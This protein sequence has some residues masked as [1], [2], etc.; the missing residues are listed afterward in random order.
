MF[1][2]T[3]WRDLRN[4]Y[5]RDK[6]TEST[7]TS[8]ALY[9]Q[10]KGSIPPHKPTRSSLPQPRIACCPSARSPV[11]SSMP[12][13]SR[14]VIQG[15]SGVP[16][17]MPRVACGQPTPVTT[18]AEV[19]DKKAAA[20]W[21]RPGI[22]NGNNLA[23]QFASQHADRTN[24]TAAEQHQRARLGSG[25]KNVEGVQRTNP[26]AVPCGPA[27]DAIQSGSSLILVI[28]VPG[29][30]TGIVQGHW[31]ENH[32]IRLATGE[33]HSRDTGDGNQ[34]AVIGAVG[35]TLPEIRVRDQAVQEAPATWLPGRPPT[36][37]QMLAEKV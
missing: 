31:T 17:T 10:M 16:E 12:A 34:A 19:Y 9:G 14:P 6:I 2:G 23:D 8:K 24:R 13:N 33:G 21:L 32:E 28:Q 22:T 11:A 35:R 20:G 27:I 29:I 7:S 3:I 30:P 4:Q 36:S 1:P 37:V 26:S 5:L 25:T 15:G 18:M